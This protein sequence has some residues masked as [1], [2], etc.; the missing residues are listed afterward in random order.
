MI[1]KYVLAWFGMMMLAIINGGLRDFAYKSHV[2][3]LPAHQISTVILII[4]FAGYF[5]FL[6]A[7]W[8]LRSASQVWRPRAAKRDVLNHS[9]V[10]I[11][12]S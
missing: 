7:V 11:G 6:A 8:P 2:G 1:L 5:R 3:D 9:I 10:T 12:G 4:L